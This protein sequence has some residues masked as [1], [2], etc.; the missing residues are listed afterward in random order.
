MSKNLGPI[1]F[2]L[3]RKIM[4]QQSFTNQLSCELLDLEH[5]KKLNTMLDQTVGTISQ[6][7]LEEQIDTM[8][9]HGWLQDKI[10]IVEVRLGYVVE[11]IKKTTGSLVQAQQIALEFG[12]SL[13]ESNCSTPE[14]GYKLI[15][16]NLLNGM[17]CDRV[18]VILEHDE[19]HLKYQQ[20]VEIHDKFWSQADADIKDYYLL[21]N[22]IIEGMLSKCGLTFSV[23]NNEIYEIKVS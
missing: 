9:I 12:R 2:W 13:C 14:A 11:E 19:N 6:E 7:S 8:N 18:N 21:R 4:I 23:F 3:Y 10:R 16:D 17:P 20:S 22:K 15:E 1:H 5:K